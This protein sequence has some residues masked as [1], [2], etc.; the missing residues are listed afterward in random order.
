MRTTKDEIYAETAK[1]AFSIQSEHETFERAFE[2]ARNMFRVIQQCET[3]LIMNTLA[4][5]PP[6]CKSEAYDPDMYGFGGYETE[7]TLFEDD[8]EI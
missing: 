8:E 4:Y 1:L 5:K 2:R 7:E 3:R 6:V